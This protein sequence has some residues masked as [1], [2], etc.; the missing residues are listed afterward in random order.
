MGLEKH[1]RKTY[2]NIIAD[3]SIRVKTSESD[4][5]AVKREYELKNG[6]KGVK[7]ELVYDS[8]SG[9][10]H[11]IEFYE[12]EYGKTLQVT[13]DDVVLSL[14]LASNYAE[15]LMKKLPS[16]KMS[17]EVKLV[18]YSFTDDTG[19]TK[20]GVTLSQG[21]KLE[22]YYYDKKNKKNLHK[23]PEIDGDYSKF[24]SDDWKAYFIKVRKFLI[25][26]TEKLIEK[27]NLGKKSTD[28]KKLAEDAKEFA[29]GDEINPSDIPF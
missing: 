6:T 28:V 10:I 14:S 22:N 29:N 3:G 25:A 12:G 20:K 26:E 8:L 13:V 17:L 16:I 24:D 21:D 7:Y 19:K 18:P 15:D 5:D 4:P 11:Q 2:A 9:M 23:Y 27:N 1:D